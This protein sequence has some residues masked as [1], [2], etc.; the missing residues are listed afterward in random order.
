MQDSAIPC[1]AERQ[2]IRERAELILAEARRLRDRL[3]QA[4]GA[5]AFALRADGVVG[6]PSTLGSLRSSR[7]RTS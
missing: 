5:V 6:G 3:D 1:R 4:T 2:R 7:L